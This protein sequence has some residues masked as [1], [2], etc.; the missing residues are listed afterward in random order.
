MH[1]RITTPA[2]PHAAG[3]LHNVRNWLKE[4]PEMRLDRERLET[5][6]CAPELTGGLE[7]APRP[8]RL[9]PLHSPCGVNGNGHHRNR[10]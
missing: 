5:L 3:I 4:N 7:G 6:C 2:E 10:S 9:G 1:Y 8:A